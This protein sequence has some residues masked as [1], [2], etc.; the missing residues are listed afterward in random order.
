MLLWNQ[1]CNFDFQSTF[2]GEVMRPCVEQW[3]STAVNAALDSS[4]AFMK[5]VGLD[6]SPVV[7]SGCDDAYGQNR[8]ELLFC[9][10][11]L[12]A[13][14]K[15]CSIPDDAEA[16]ARGGFGAAPAV[17]HPSTPHLLPLLY[18]VF[19]LARVLHGLWEPSARQSLSRGYV[20]ALDMLETE[21]SNILGQNGSAAAA[22]NAL[23]DDTSGDSSRVQGPL[24]RMQSFLERLHLNTFS[25]LGL[26]GE[27]LTGEFY[28][29]NGLPT[30]VA[31]TA[32]FCLEYIP[33]YRLRTVMKIFCR[34]FIA[35]CPS[36]WNRIVLQPFLAHLC[37]AMLQRLTTTWQRQMAL[38]QQ[39]TSRKTDDDDTDNILNHLE[40][41]DDVLSRML[42]KDYLD[43]LKTIL[44]VA[45]SSDPPTPDGLMDQDAIN[46]ATEST[47]SGGH[48][49]GQPGNVVISELGMMALSDAVLPRSIVQCIVSALWWP[50]TT[51]SMKATLML[52]S[53]VKHWTT[54]GRHAESFP[55]AE[56]C[57]FC[58]TNVLNGL[59]VLG[60]HEG[61]QASLIQLA[62]QV[63][64]AFRPV[65]PSLADSLLQHTQCNREDLA[66]YEE[67][68]F[69]VNGLP[70]KPTQ[71]LDRAKRELFRKIASQV[72]SREP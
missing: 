43:V 59:Q 48:T 55:N 4:T 26:L 62:V 63:Y 20:K 7:E 57:D 52:S 54:L 50:D 40:V 58:L 46:D 5:F 37:P 18:N 2:I 72:S 28:A 41:V 51:N 32:C 67:K 60:Q 39:M 9:T 8:S 69:G 61:N 53:I 47:N 12:L 68:L 23:G 31:G 29:L 35:C 66:A 38:H 56:W 34:P 71:K 25:L 6:Q 15:R 11:V 33:D 21:M 19:R 14:V 13:V 64:D 24:E 17:R 42:T 16:A 70:I 1:Y 27:T 65:Y 49:N 22:P 45:S 44:F 30:A 10:N 36:Q 3:T